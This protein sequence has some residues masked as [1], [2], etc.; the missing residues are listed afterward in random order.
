MNRPRNAFAGGLLAFGVLAGACS[1]NAGESVIPDQATA[2]AGGTIV[3]EARDCSFVPDR[4][5]SETASLTLQLPNT[6]AEQ[7]SLTVYQSDDY[8]EPVAGAVIEP[9]GPGE[10]E[11]V[12]F[13]VAEGATT[14][15]FRCEVHPDEMNGE[16]SVGASDA[17][18]GITTAQATAGASPTQED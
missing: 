2:R 7:H 17:P 3:V 14:L 8:A 9:I 13:D 18:T 12:S 10:T 6:G 11:S 5:E 1:E 16:I 4:A 15:N